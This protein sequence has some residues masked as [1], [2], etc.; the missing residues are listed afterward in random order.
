MRSHMR[1]HALSLVEQ[2]QQYIFY[3]EKKEFWHFFQ[4][5]A[6]QSAKN[7]PKKPQQKGME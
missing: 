7:I 5:K 4:A 1:Y 2:L 3:K 6:V